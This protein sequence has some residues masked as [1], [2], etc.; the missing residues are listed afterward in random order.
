MF[1]RMLLDDGMDWFN[2]QQQVVDA[3]NEAQLRM[4]DYWVQSGN[5]RAL[6]PL[7]RFDQYV[8]DMRNPSTFPTPIGVPQTIGGNTITRKPLYVRNCLVSLNDISNPLRDTFI[9]H[10]NYVEPELFLNAEGGITSYNQGGAFVQR[11][12]MN[13]IHYSVQR[14]LDGV[15][16]WQHYL[17]FTGGDVLFDAYAIIGFIAYPLLYSRTQALEVSPEYHYEVCTLAAEM[18]NGNDVGER[19]RSKVAVPE[20]GQKLDILMLGTTDA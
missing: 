8:T 9:L 14:Q 20:F 3:I 18:L 17:L 2:K 7:F 4:I 15:S 11:A 1:V 6:R 16:E 19:E 10:A 12:L 13:N 5:E